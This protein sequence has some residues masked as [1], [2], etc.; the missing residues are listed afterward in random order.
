MCSKKTV[1]ISTSIAIIIGLAGF[2]G[3][4]AYEKNSLSK[5]GL[6]RSNAQNGSGQQRRQS[7]PG[8]GFR[9]GGAGNAGDFIAGEIISK[10]DKS[11]TVKTGDGGSK[12]IF[13]SD[14]TSV[15]KAVQGTVS[16][17]SNGNQVMVNGKSNADGT[18]TAQNIQIRPDQ[19]PGFDQRQD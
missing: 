15:G 17:L 4:T 6:L 1:A 9:P 13:F 12:I 18:V 19:G 14:S 5:R 3:G 16:D 8:A 7:G 10:D 2:F 11:I